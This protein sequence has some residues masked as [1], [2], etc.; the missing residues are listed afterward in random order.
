MSKYFP[1]NNLLTFD[2]I[3]RCPQIN[4][5]AIDTALADLRGAPG[6]PPLEGP[7]S[8]IFIFKN[9]QNSPNLGVG[10]PP[11]NNPGSAT[12]LGDHW[13]NASFYLLKL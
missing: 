10:A 13:H 3:L 7:N 11:G 12:V 4:V 9:V 1:V 2:N 5:C 8:F 6:T